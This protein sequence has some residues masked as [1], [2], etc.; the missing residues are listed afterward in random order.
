MDKANTLQRTRRIAARGPSIRPAVVRLRQPQQE[1]S[2]NLRKTLTRVAW[3]SIGLGLLMEVLLFAVR[4]GV[5]G[6][7]EPFVAEMVNRVSW[8]FLVC[9]GL[10]VG[11]SFTG[12]RGL[13]A[14]LAGL[15]VA[16]AAFIAARGLHRGAA[17]LLGTT[18]PSPDSPVIMVLAGL[19]GIEYLCLGLLLFW[20]GR[21]AWGGAMA[22]IAAGLAVGVIFGGIVLLLTPAV[23][24][25][26]AGLLSWSINE[27]LFPVG[28]S[29]VLFGSS[30]VG[31]RV[32]E[33]AG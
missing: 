10:A 17:E 21:K 23:A 31:K 12:G 9:M 5:V 32:V 2:Y 18:G 27:L 8:S 3:L 28:C 33:A 29:L 25:S 1:P 24:A 7:V 16:P 14:G 19:R 20:I 11:E 30:V 4:Y 26:T 15:F 6:Q 22:H 13:W